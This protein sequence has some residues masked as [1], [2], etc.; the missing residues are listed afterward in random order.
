MEQN[1]SWELTVR[2]ASQEISLLLCNTKVHYRVHNSQLLVLFRARRIH[3]TPSKPISQISN[4]VLYFHLCLVFSSGL[5]PSGFSNKILHAF[6]NSL[7]RAAC[8]VHLI[9]LDLIML[10]IHDEEYKLWNSS[11]CNFYAE[12]IKIKFAI[13]NENYVMRKRNL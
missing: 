1:R 5:F 2:S 11:V 13:V 7:I 9:S 10:I 8:P 4:L 3:S 6:L 12:K